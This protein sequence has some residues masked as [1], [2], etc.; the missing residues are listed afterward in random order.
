VV[1]IRESEVDPIL[2]DACMMNGMPGTQY[3]GVAGE[4]VLD[5]T[6]T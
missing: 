6:A 1:Y 4:K 2:G 5:S 3:A